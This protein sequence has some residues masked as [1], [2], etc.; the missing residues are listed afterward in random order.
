[1]KRLVV[2]NVVGLTPRALRR[3]PRLGQL[4]AGGFR[5]ALEPVFPAVTC[6]AQA[7]MLTGLL[8][9]EH[10][11]VGNGWWHDDLAEILFWRQSNRLVAGEKVWESGRQRSPK[12]TCANLFWWFAMYS[13]ADVTLTPRPAYPADGRK[14]PDLW[15]HPPALRAEIQRELGPFPLFD[16]WGPRAG[17]ASSEWIAEAS[18]RVIERTRPTLALVYLPHLDYDFQRFGP[19]H[20]RSAAAVI[21]IDRVAGGLAEAARAGGA[22]VIVLSEYGITKVSGDVALNRALRRAGF[23]RVLDQIGFELLDAGASR[24]FAVA[25]HQAAH[26]HVADE[27]D[28]AA[29][30]RVIES[31]PG[32]DSVLDRAEQRSLGIDH[33]RAGDLVAIAKPDRWFSYYYWLDPEKAPDFA[34]TVDIH[35]K[36]GYDPAELF[37]DP[38]IPLVKARVARKLL[39]KKLG[40]RALL[41]V[42]PTDGSLVRGS[43]GRLPDDPEDGPV[44]LSTSRAGASERLRQTDVRDVILETI[45]EGR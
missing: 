1:M 28:I 22:E 7:T 35:R 34:P 8:P 30:R 29:V 37:L 25:D 11:V 23:L 45:F 9:R 3:A 33:P 24:A 41:D 43:H 32:V 31:E 12:F 20:E 21:E 16:F 10:G 5:A 4:A 27:K 26:V 19:D 6:P 40:F 42:I 39:A 44:L 36:P 15:S 13:S 17:I 2:L 38:A 18:R 14:L